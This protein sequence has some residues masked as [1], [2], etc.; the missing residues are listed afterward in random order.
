MS[1][2]ARGPLVAGVVWVFGDFFKETKV[3]LGRIFYVQEQC[4]GSTF[5][6]APDPL[7]FFFLDPDP[8]KKSLIWIRVT[9]KQAQL[10]KVKL[11]VIVI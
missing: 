1:M 9:P 5:I 4:F 11:N 7:G 3:E 6:P 2:E 8:L 10:S